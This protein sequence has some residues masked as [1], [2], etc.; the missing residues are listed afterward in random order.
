MIKN[1]YE[2]PEPDDGRTPHRNTPEW[3]LRRLNRIAAALWD[4]R[5]LLGNDGRVS[6]S[7]RPDDQATQVNIHVHSVESV[8]IGVHKHRCTSPLNDR[9][10]RCGEVDRRCEHLRAV[11]QLDRR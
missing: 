5:P 9:V 11:R 6:V 8:R 4:A 2:L 10:Y 7:V 1:G 3:Q